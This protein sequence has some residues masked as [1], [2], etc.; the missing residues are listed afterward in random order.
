MR[1]PASIQDNEPILHS[2][3]Y[4]TR[5]AKKGGHTELHSILDAALDL[6]SNKKRKKSLDNAESREAQK[7]I[8]FLVKFHKASKMQKKQVLGVIDKIEASRKITIQ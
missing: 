2:L 6:A 8:A 1:T 3:E 5:E 4:L 7:I